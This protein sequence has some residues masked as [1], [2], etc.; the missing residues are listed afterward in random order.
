MRFALA[1]VLGLSACTTYNVQRTARSPHPTVP[2]ND[3]QPME[4]PF[5]ISTGLSNAADLT[6]PKVGNKLASV[7][8]PS[9]QARTELRF[10]IRDRGEIGLVDERGIGG[11]KRADPTQAP[12]EQ[13]SPGGDGVL[14]RYSIDTGVPGFSVGLQA[15]MMVWTIPYV[16][17]VTCSMN[18]TTQFTDVTHSRDTAM[19]FGAGVT[20]SYRTGNLTIYGGVYGRNEPTIERK[21]LDAV[22]VD[23]EPVRNGPINILLHAGVS[24]RFA[25]RFLAVADI[26]QDLMSDPVQFGPGVGVGLQVELGDHRAPG[27]PGPRP[28]GTLPYNGTMMLPPAQ[29]GGYIP[30]PPPPPPPVDGPGDHGSAN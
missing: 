27:E 3:G 7:E 4:H 29:P 28:P 5:A 22:F 13:G 19:T 16:Q 25:E 11:Y 8:T 9:V 30:Q 2:L 1:A 14:F 21:S 17:Y 15:D 18:C 6:D 26:H 24:Y 10:R 20:P 12:V 23:D